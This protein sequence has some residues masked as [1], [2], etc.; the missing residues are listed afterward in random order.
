VS[1]NASGRI[2]EERGGGQNLPD[3]EIEFSRIATS[4]S[5]LE[6][7]AAFVVLLPFGPRCA[8]GECFGKVGPQ[9]VSWQSAHVDG[10]RAKAKSP[11]EFELF[12]M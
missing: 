5:R 10:A 1:L 8:A 12:G 2:D 11:P 7:V 9:L 4:Q 3:R 6:N